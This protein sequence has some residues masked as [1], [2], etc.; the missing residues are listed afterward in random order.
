MDKILIIDDEVSVVE[1][2]TIALE[3][4]PYEIITTN[5]PQEGI[6][7][8]QEHSPFLIILDMKM[9]KMD[10]MEVI[11]YLIENEVPNHRY[12]C[13]L[14]S[15]PHNQ[16]NAGLT[17]RDAN[18]HVVVLTGVGDKEMMLKCSALGVDYFLNKPIHIFT[19][20]GIIHNIHRLKT[21][22][23]ELSQL[24]KEECGQLESE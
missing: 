5:D 24:F 14:S 19:L 4:L 10:G 8:F 23:D 3:T 1:T 22:R 16:E 11:E 9:D 7:L 17:L 18:F 2:L 20:R 12:S 13:I 21:S 6:R 15:Q